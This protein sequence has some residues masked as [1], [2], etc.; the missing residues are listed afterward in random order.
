VVGNYDKNTKLDN[1]N[2]PEGNS[3]IA[4]SRE[5]TEVK[6]R[7]SAGQ[8]KKKK[9]NKEEEGNEVGNHEKHSKLDDLNKP[10]EI[11]PIPYSQEGTEVKKNTSTT[12]IHSNQDEGATSKIKKNNQRKKKQ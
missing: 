5:G 1:L 2:K 6:K 3:T 4:C 7:K 11:S 10:K 8:K 12:Q 9:K